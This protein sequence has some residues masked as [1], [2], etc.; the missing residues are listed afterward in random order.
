MK[1]AFKIQSLIKNREELSW[2][3]GKQLLVIS[4]IMLFKQLYQK[5]TKQ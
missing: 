5:G 3:A 2:A 4:N 1:F